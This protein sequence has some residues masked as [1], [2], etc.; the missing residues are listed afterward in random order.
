MNSPFTGYK[1]IKQER[2]VYLSGV[3]FCK[4]VL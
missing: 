1:S 2:R 3:V 4:L